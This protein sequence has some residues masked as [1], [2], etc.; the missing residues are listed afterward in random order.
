MKIFRGMAKMLAKEQTVAAPDTWLGRISNIPPTPKGID[1]AGIFERVAA[2]FHL[3]PGVWVLLILTVVIAVIMRY[4]VLGR[5]LFAIGSNEETAKLCGINVNFYKIL[6]YGLA[7]LLTGLSGAILFCRLSIGS[8]TAA[9][10]MELDIIAAVVI[11]GASLNGGEGSAVGCII[12][13]LL[14]FSLRNGCSLCGFPS[15]VI[16]VVIGSVLI[17]AVAIDRLK[18]LD[19]NSWLGRRLR[20]LRSSKVNN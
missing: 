20:S 1:E 3:A 2:L 11:G 9:V 5:Y 7:G 8:P 6:T 18:H 12:G 15:W 10:G 14:I 19:E 13:A 16:D 17:L 4:T